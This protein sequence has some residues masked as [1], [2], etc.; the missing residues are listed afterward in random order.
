VAKRVSLQGKGAELFFGGG[1][2][3]VAE[4]NATES[5]DSPPYGA[6]KEPEQARVH[7]RIGASDDELL[8]GLG[9][10]QRLASSTF[11]FQPDELELLDAMFDE[12]N[13]AKPRRIS[14]NDLVRLGVRWLLSDYEANAERSLAARLLDRL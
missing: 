9:E 7:A 8:R 13:R 2:R 3:A 10:K 4:D 5:T 12:L 11:R 14:K 6:S 1:P